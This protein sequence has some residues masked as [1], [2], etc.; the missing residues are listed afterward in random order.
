MSSGS[1]FA[2]VEGAEQY[3]FY[4]CPATAT[5]LPGSHYVLACVREVPALQDH[6][7]LPGAPQGGWDATTA[8]GA[9]GGAGAWL[10]SARTSSATARPS[11]TLR[12]R[13]SVMRYIDDWNRLT[14][15]IGH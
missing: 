15:R 3:C 5:G 9:G 6:A 1:R 7:R 13:E 12:C 8:G 11:S 14:E 10:S 4:D 2:G